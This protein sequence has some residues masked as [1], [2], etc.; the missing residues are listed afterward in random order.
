MRKPAT[1]EPCAG[2]PLAR[3]GG[4]GGPNLPYPYRKPARR[5]G[6]WMAGSSPATAPLW[7]HTI[8]ASQPPDRRGA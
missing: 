3:F 6:P 1:G 8:V 4:R 2:E 5:P 7:L